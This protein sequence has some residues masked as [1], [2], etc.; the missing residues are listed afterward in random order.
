MPDQ[1]LRVLWVEA[2]PGDSDPTSC[3]LVLHFSRAVDSFEEA[4]LKQHL[5][6]EVHEND[7]M[8]AHWPKVDLEDVAKNPKALSGK[9]LNA[10]GFGSKRRQQEQQQNARIAQLIDYINQGLQQEDRPDSA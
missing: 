2:L 3:T 7:K 5:G 1:E 9:V 6:V 4:S 8:L 10:A